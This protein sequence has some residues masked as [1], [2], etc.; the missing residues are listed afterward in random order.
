MTDTSREQRVSSAF[1]M[2]ADTLISEYDLVDLLHTLMDECLALLDVHAAGLLLANA[3]GEL[4]LVAS[5]SERAELVEVLQLDAGAGPCVESFTTAT[6]VALPDVD[7]AP[8]EW[9]QFSA[10]ARQQG[11]HAVHAVPLRL[12]SQVI[13]V[14]GLF[15]RSTGTLAAA[16][17][18][19]AQ[20]LADVA[21]IGILQE[22]LVHESGLV[23]EQLQHALDSRIVIEQAKGV[24][25][26]SSG[27]DMDAAFG[28]LRAHARG[29]NLS[30]RSVAEGVVG[31]TLH[32]STLASGAKRE[33]TR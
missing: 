5:T 27:V 25:A 28:L 31:R 15:R 8:E 13:G 14:M 20:A 21:T 18:A 11:F 26:E 7:E 2:L 22:R 3:Q 23:T 12:R 4:D 19:L 32:P 17:A 9:A 10:A 29:N 33:P 16:D 1:V 6:P 30:L 24:V